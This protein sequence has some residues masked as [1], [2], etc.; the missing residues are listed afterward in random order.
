MSEHL[1]VL[2]CPSGRDGRPDAKQRWR[3]DLAARTLAEL[4]PDA[5]LVFS[6]AGEADVMAADFTTRW[7]G[8][9]TIVVEPR[10]TTTW[11]NIGFG[12][13]LIP[14]GGVV[15]IVSDPRHVRRAEAYWRRRLPDRAQELAPSARPRWWER[16]WLRLESAVYEILVRAGRYRPDGGMGPAARA[17]DWLRAREAR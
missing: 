4:A 13:A 16:P 1:L 5:T 6:G 9:P 14:A 8:G 7:G 11:E 15:R 17:L 12:A 2:G 3:V 10:A